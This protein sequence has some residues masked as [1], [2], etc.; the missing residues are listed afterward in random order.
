MDK[1]K[2][3]LNSHPILFRTAKK[4]YRG[5]I[6]P[7]KTGYYPFYLFYQLFVQQ[8]EVSSLENLQFSNVMPFEPHTWRYGRG[9]DKAFRRY[10]TAYQ[11]GIKYFVKIATKNDSSVQNE[12]EIQTVLSKK[13]YDW[14][15]TCIMAEKNFCKN[16]SVLIVKYEKGLRKFELP[17]TK[18]AFNKLCLKFVRI[19]DDLY[20]I[21]VVHSDIHAGNLMLDLD[22]NLHLLDF[23]ISKFI[24]MGNDVNYLAR[25]G[26]FY[27]NTKN[28]R[29]Y[30]DAYS[31]V[32]LMD[33]IG[34]PTEWKD[35]AYYLE[36]KK[37]INRCCNVVLME[38]SK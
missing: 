30:D 38:Q 33:R 21:K 23:G 28:K 26:T 29:I 20:A 37:R 12:I 35:E 32:C 27:R 6:I 15:P 8:K 22:N 11:N 36:I 24:D 5:I 2:K 17:S 1:I 25:P 19:L 18:E 34:L 10:Y 31:F 16:M 3:T 7:L 9:K 13:E 14:T 4:L